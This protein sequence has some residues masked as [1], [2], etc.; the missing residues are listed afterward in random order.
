MKFRNTAFTLILA[1]FMCSH[2]ATAQEVEAEHANEPTIGLGLQAY[3][4]GFMP[5][6]QFEHPLSAHGLLHLRVGL[7]IFDH[8]D[9]GKH[10]EEIGS[11]YGG[12][13]GYKHFFNDKA[14][15]WSL[16][17]KTDVCFNSVDWR[18]GFDLPS[19]PEKGTTDITVL[20]PTLEL[21][22]T[23][24]LTEQLYFTPSAAFGLE[25]N[26]QTEGEP[27]GEGPIVL[28]GVAFGMKL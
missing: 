15:K 13:L 7:N 21:G 22:Y 5:G 20:Q 23:M 28:V 12:S 9:L 6:L 14:T 1:L 4:T 16:M 25:W 24:M 3:P 2:I 11:G 19:A 17:L 27:T 10:E 18:D 26:V 8:K